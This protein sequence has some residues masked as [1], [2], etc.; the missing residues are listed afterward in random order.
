MASPTAL[1]D[2]RRD[3]EEIGSN[4][5]DPV[6]AKEPVMRKRTATT[7]AII[8]SLAA[9]GAPAASARPVDFLPASQH[10]SAAVDSRPEKTMIPVTGLVIP[11]HATNGTGSTPA[12]TPQERRRVAGLSAYR[13]GQLAA[14]FA[15]AANTG[16]PPQAIVRVH[17]PQSG[18]DWGDAGLGAAG[19]LALSVIAVGG[20]FAVSGRRSRRSTAVPN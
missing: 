6:R 5:S 4:A 19:G 18:F 7:T 10:S 20:A 16:S 8:L 15:T 17:A 2:D 13:E 12:P 11:G 1:A 9:A 14:S 3:N